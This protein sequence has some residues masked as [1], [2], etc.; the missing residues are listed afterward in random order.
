VLELS[1]EWGI[2]RF[3]DFSARQTLTA[4]SPWRSMPN[5]PA[6]F[7]IQRNFP[8]LAGAVRNSRKCDRFQRRK[9]ADSSVRADPRPFPVLGMAATGPVGV[10]RAQ[11]GG[12]PAR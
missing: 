2:L 1:D 10:T 8:P 7:S 4:P 11:A 12:N 5:F 6:N 3:K 9:M